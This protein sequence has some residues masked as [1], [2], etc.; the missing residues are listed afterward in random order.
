MHCCLGMESALASYGSPFRY[1]PYGREYHVEYDSTFENKET[2]EVSLGV[3]AG[4]S[5]CP[6]CGSKLPKELSEEW[7]Q[8]VTNKFNV[9]DTLDKEELKKV[10]EEYMTEER[11]RK[12]GL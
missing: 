10:P 7:E 3:A 6:W 1:I 9:I 12:R 11:W 8:E 2:G 4:I 5:Y